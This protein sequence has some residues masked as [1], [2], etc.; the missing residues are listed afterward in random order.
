MGLGRLGALGLGGVAGRPVMSTSG[1]GLGSDGLPSASVFCRPSAWRQVWSL[2][3]LGLL[4]QDV[5]RRGRGDFPGG[6]DFAFIRGR[7]LLDRLGLGRL[8]GARGFVGLRT[9]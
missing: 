7:R 9:R 6:N 4:A 2:G 3:G 1:S 5:R 8:L